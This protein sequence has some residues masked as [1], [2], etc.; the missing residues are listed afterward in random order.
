MATSSQISEDCFLGTNASRKQSSEICDEV[1]K[2]YYNKGVA[3]WGSQYKI[4]VGGGF[5]KLRTPYLVDAGNVTYADLFSILPFDNEIVLGKISGYYLKSR[6][7]NSTG[8]DY[9]VYKTIS[10]A[11][12]ND[13][14]YYYIVIDSYTSSYRSNNITEIARL[15]GTYARDLLAEFVSEGGW[16]R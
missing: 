13:N 5:L 14:E 10:A 3:E 6:F 11:E 9:H 16:A 1:A 2:L 15:K 12:V 8:G 7:L 4:A